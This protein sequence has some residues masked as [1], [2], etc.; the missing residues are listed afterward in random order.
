MLAEKL[1]SNLDEGDREVLVEMMKPQ[2]LEVKKVCA[3]R[4]IAVIERILWPD[5]IPAPSKAGVT[6]VSPEQATPAKRGQ[7]NSPVQTPPLTMEPNSPESSSPPSTHASV[8]ETA[9]ENQKIAT[10][11]T[12]SSK[13][14]EVLVQ[15]E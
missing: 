8:G 5:G 2:V 7:V 15:E 4:Q 9:D 13:G 14:T 6:V 1:L 11:S 3:S 10:D 12:D